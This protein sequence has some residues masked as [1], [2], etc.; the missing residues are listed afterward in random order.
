MVG[1]DL[2]R[3]SRDAADS[4]EFEDF[5]VNSS[6][7]ANSSTTSNPAIS[8]LADSIDKSAS[9]SQEFYWNLVV[10]NALIAILPRPWLWWTALVA[11]FRLARP[12]WWLSFPLLPIPDERYWHFRMSTAYGQQGPVDPRIQ[13]APDAKDILSY[14]QWCRAMN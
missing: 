5:G 12:R 6:D 4:G 2:N 1:I 7:L 3:D 13:S 14:L 11:I 9:D 10:W 8:S